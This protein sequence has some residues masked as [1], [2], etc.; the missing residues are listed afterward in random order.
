MIFQRLLR[1]STPCL[2]LCLV[3]VGCPTASAATPESEVIV[4]VRSGA[5]T[6]PIG[7]SEANCD[8]STVRSEQLYSTLRKW[9]VTRMRRV[10]PWFRPDTPLPLGPDGSVL[11]RPDRS[12]VYVLEVGPENQKAVVQELQALPEVL[13]AEANQRVFALGFPNDLHEAQWNMENKGQTG[14]TVDADV[15]AL[16][17]WNFTHGSSADLVAVLD[18]GNGI[19]A[20][21]PDLNGRIVGSSGTSSHSTMIAGIIGAKGNNGQGIAGMNWNGSIYSYAMTDESVASA[22]DAVAFATDQGI[23]IHNDA[24]GHSQFSQD[25]DFEFAYAYRNNVLSCVAAPETD[26]N[27]GYPISY[28]HGIIGVGA[29]TNTD[30]PTTYTLGGTYID[31]VAPGGNDDGVSGRDIFSTMPGST[32][33]TGSGTSLATAHVAGLASL[34]ARYAA[35]SL[36][37]TLYND[38]LEQIIRL[39]ADHANGN[40]NLVGRGRTNA[41]R[42]IEWISKPNRI[43]Q[44]TAVGGTDVWASPPYTKTFIGNDCTGEGEFGVILHVVRRDVTFPV[45]FSSQP[46]IWGRGVVTKGYDDASPNFGENWCGVAA[47]T[48]TGC[49]LETYVFQIFSPNGNFIKWCPD[50]PAHAVFAWTAMADPTLNASP[51]SVPGS[52]YVPQAVNVFGTLLEGTAAIPNFR[53]CPNNDA[54]SVPNNARIKVKLMNGANPNVN[55]PAWDIYVL[56]NGGTA[57]QGFSGQ[58]ADSVVA[59]SVW[60]QAPLCPD[61]QLIQADAPTDANGETYITFKGALPSNPGVAVRDPSRKWGHYDSELPVY[62]SKVK[63]PGRLTAAS[64][65]GTYVLQIKNLDLEGGIGAG[66]GEQVLSNDFNS[67]AIHTGELDSVDAKNWWRDFDSDGTVGVT[68]YNLISGHVGHSCTSPNNP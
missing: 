19:Q 26:H 14:G 51:P 36:G 27:F 45:A 55:F 8:R 38:D 15:D 30:F 41:G 42:A 31:V 2:L 28:G 66:P 12:L 18:P 64:G 5:V 20:S 67:V 37:I 58:G 48:P 49:T 29:S 22:I 52:F 63:L 46:R 44:G 43:F 9:N 56:F 57:A 62:A 53:A 7:M 33:G 1:A 10:S 65:D 68:D 34:L 4:R 24:W 21:H 23:K 17:A 39:T 16:G 47:Q 35:D 25:L 11:N 60:N 3:Y 61:V 13:M 32:Y 6:V 54:P 50:D 59:N 40:Q